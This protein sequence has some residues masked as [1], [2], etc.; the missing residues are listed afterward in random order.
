MR[1]LGLDYGTERIGMALSD[2]L[3]MI[4]QPVKFIRAYPLSGVWAQLRSVHRATPY[5][6]IIIGMPRNMNGTYGPA[7]AKV[8]HFIQHLN[9]EIDI[10]TKTWDERLSSTQASRVLAQ[11]KVPKRKRK[12]KVDKIAAAIILQSYLDSVQL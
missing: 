10:P 9:Q 4:A 3:G 12:G 7:A 5:R 8:K 1:I 11:T 2:E 6:L